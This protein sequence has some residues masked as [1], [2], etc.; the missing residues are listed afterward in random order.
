MNWILKVKVG[1]NWF[2]I[3]IDNEELLDYT[4]DLYDK[5]VKCTNILLFRQITV[6]KA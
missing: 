1:I 4:I 6:I 3:D 5:M 2:K